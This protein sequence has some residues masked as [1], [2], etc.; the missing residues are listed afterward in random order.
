MKAMKRVLLAAAVAWISVGVVVTAGWHTPKAPAAG[1]QVLAQSPAQAAGGVTGVPAEYRQMLRT[2]CVTCHNERANLPAGAPLYLD[3]VNLDDPAADA[4]DWER[5]V[6]KLGVGAMPPQGMPSPGDAQLVEFRAWLMETLDR[7]AS[8][9][10]NPGHY[11]LHRLNRTEYANAIRDLVAVEIDVSEL[12][13]SD[14][15]DFGFDNIATALPTSPFLLERYLTAAQRIATLAVGDTE[16]IASGASYPISLEVTQRVH[17]PGLPLGTRGGILVRHIFPADGEYDLGIKLNR[18]ILVAYSGIEGH[19][20]PHEFVITLDGEQVFSAL[21]GGPEDHA[22]NSEDPNPVADEL[23]E[24]LKTRLAVT[25]G[26]HDIGFTWV[27]R[28]TQ[29]QAVWEPPDRDTQEVHMAGGLPRIKFANV[30]GPFTVSGISSTP[31]RER[32][33]VCQ[34]ASASEE[35]ACAEQIFSTLARRAFRRPVDAADLEAPITFYREARESGGDFDAGIRAGVTRILASPSFLYR[36]E[37]DPESLPAG[38]AH[39]VTDVELASRLSFFLWSSIP[40]DEL[41]DLAI[42]NR[43]RQPGVLEAQVR[44]M[45]ADERSDALVANFVGQWLQLR[46]LEARVVPDILLHVNFDDNIRKGFRRETEMFFSYIMRENQNALE[47]LD[48]DY[49]FLNERLARHY[50]IPGVYGTRFRRVE[51]TDP[52]RHGLLGHGSILSLTSIATRT[53]PVIRGKYVMSV[54]LNTPPLPPPPNVPDLEASAEGDR[55]NTVRE[56]LERHRANPF[57]GSCHRN[58]DPV[59]FALEN[60]NS[61][62]QWREAD[63][64]GLPVD[65]L[66]VLADGTEVDGPIALREA[67]LSRPDIFVGAITENMLIYALGRG[68]EPVDK[69]VVRDVVGGAAQNDYRFMSIITGI[70][71]SAPFQMRTKPQPDTG[72]RVAQAN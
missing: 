25:A 62:G 41:L 2:Y 12:L 35:P 22:A 44:R 60:F 7:V 9:Q 30:D 4:A 1:P 59:G 57:C 69:V 24:R 58:I 56:Q 14:G 10:Q 49:T 37:T 66:G 21:V 54:M 6:K 71:E 46:N 50:G 26:P 64:S 72:N 32:I 31:S 23:D 38:E 47:L 65:T 68:L 11:V 61:A 55:P 42:A 19:E 45:I 52:N 33:L 39:P 29:D 27:D 40:D 15:G 18:T 51:L 36:A 53:S 17:V 34:P 5:V 13:P 28:P 16:M 20:T 67:L 3:T 63:Y 8:Q 43:L 48:A 70:V